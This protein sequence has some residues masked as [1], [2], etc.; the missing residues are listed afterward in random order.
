LFLRVFFFMLCLARLWHLDWPHL[1]PLH[2]RAGPC[3]SRPQRLRRHE[4]PQ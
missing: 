1:Q 3:T 4:P 2:S